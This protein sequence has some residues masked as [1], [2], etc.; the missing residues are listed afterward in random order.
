MN[1]CYT[2]ITQ[3]CKFIVEEQHIFLGLKFKGKTMVEPLNLTLKSSKILFH[4]Y[5]CV[6]VCKPL[7]FVSELS[8]TCN[9][10]STHIF[11]FHIDF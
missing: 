3:P 10:A 8:A 5:V 2:Y 9:T 7:M 6:C 1:I 11:L 4:I